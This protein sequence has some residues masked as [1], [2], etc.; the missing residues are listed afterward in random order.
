MVLEFVPS[1]SLGK[2][3][4]RPAT[5]GVVP[6]A[7][8]RVHA[9]SLDPERVTHLPG[10]PPELAARRGDEWRRLGDVRTVL[11]TTGTWYVSSEGCL[12]GG[13]A[14]CLGWAVRLIADRF[15]ELDASAPDIGVDF[16]FL[17]GGAESAAL[18]EIREH[19]PGLAGAMTR[20]AKP[21]EVDIDLPTAGVEMVFRKGAKI[22]PGVLL[23]RLPDLA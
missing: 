8:V 4:F 20:A 22:T 1:E 23:A 7:G 6:L 11:A 13:P 2:L 5:V 18:A 19:A 17:V 3:G 9:A 12:D 21:G 10:R 14:D 15:S 16:S